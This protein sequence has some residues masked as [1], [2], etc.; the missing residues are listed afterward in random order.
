ME[1][2]T[3]FQKFILLFVIVGICIFTMPLDLKVV[4]LLVLKV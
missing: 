4:H 3:S 1:H 2:L